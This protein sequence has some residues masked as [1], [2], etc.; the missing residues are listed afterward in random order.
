MESNSNSTYPTTKKNVIVTEKPSVAGNYAKTLGVTE[1]KDGYYENDEYIITWC[2]G[3]LVS[4]AYPEEYDERLKKWNLE[5]LPFLPEEYKY[6]V[7]KNVSSQFRIIKSIYHR[8]DIDTIYYAGDAGREGIYIQALVRQK[9]GHSK[10]VNELVVWIDSQTD[11]EIIRGL[12]EAKPFATPKYQNLTASGYVRAIEDYATGINFSRILT[13]LYAPMLNKAANIKNFVPISVGRV[14]TC[15]LGMTVDREREILGFKPVP[16]YKVRNVVVT[17]DFEIEGNWKVVEGSRYIDS[18][19]LYD[20]S[21]FKQKADA[22]E[23]IDS[24]PRTVMVERI[25]K[26]IERKSAP[27]LFNL[28]ELQGECTKQFKISPDRTLEIAQK[29]YEKKLTTYPRTD[30]RVL[31]TAIAKEID[32]N[33]RGLTG[34]EP[35]SAYAQTILDNGWDKSFTEKSNKKYIDDTKITDHYAIIPTGTAVEDYNNLGK[36]EQDVY[37]LIV[38]R[39][40]AIFYPPAEFEKIQV[41]ERA[42]SE[43]FFASGKALLK[44]GYLEV[45]GGNTDNS[46]P[47]NNQQLLQ[48]KEGETYQTRYDIKK[49][50][51]APPKRY[52]TGNLVLAM[53]NA[54]KL[55]EDEELRAQIKGCG[56]GT[57]STRAETIK[58]LIKLGYIQVNEKTQIVTPSDFGNMVYEVVAS[59]IPAMLNPKMTAS[60]EKGL[61]AIAEGEISA[62]EYRVKLEEYVRTES[63]KIKEKDVKMDIAQ[64]IRP[65]AKVSGYENAGE[66]FETHEINAVCPDCGGIMKTASFGYACEHYGKEN[67][68]CRFA[69]GVI[70]GRSLSEEEIISLLKEGRTDVLK[71]FVSKKKKEFSAVLVLGRNE[72]G[73][74]A[75]SF[76]FEAVKPNI[77]KGAPC[78]M[79]GNNIYITKYGYGCSTYKKDD[80]TSCQFFIGKIAGKMLN[81]E[82]AKTLIRRKRVGPL[83]GF[84][85]KN[86]KKFEASLKLNEDGKVMFDFPEENLVES[87]IECPKCENRMMKGNVFYKCGCGYKI[88]YLIAGKKLTE[89]EVRTLMAGRTGLLHGFKSKK[90]NRFDAVLIADQDGKVTFEFNK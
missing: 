78:P 53:E 50:E 72:E 29:L 10:N 45:L 87:E 17:G 16:F 56:I 84:T 66:P 77:L 27:T 21:G 75:L 42:G 8:E 9:A 48:L 33:I 52:T 83:K 30:A 11:E 54:G 55:I 15:V 14:M 4:M 26:A 23:L 57:S 63:E 81:E 40:L 38:K 36:L 62:G 88:P 64:R 86:D 73:R 82:Q 5:T 1:K 61:N 79:C 24:L 49:G 89:D 28:A 2:V 65:Y 20:E 76:D 18:P 31:S 37:R 90:G 43:S 39:F 34:L 80:P 69:I 12:K 7:I 71:G 3:H 19:K 13:L 58:K 85:S 22:Q 47:E 41:T 70:A 35:L 74:A 67:G 59:T 44:P 6:S 51:T 60:W 46:K 32:K 25:E 68:A